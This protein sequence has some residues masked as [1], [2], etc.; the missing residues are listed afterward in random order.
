MNYIFS[1]CIGSFLLDENFRILKFERSQ[2]PLKSNE[3][4]ISG[5]L[6]DEDIAL[7]KYEHEA[8]L[9]RAEKL[10]ENMGYSSDKKLLR[11][12]LSALSTPEYFSLFREA[13]LKICRRAISKS[14]TPDLLII[15]QVNAISELSKSANLLSKRLREWYGL[16]NPELSEEVEDHE[17]FVLKVCSLSK[18]EVRG[19]S[20]M[21]GSLSV[22]QL[23]SLISFA[24]LVR[25]IFEEIRR[26]EA[27]LEEEM[28][29]N[30]PNLTAAVGFSIGA[31]LISLAGGIRQLAEMPSS[32][33]Q[34]LGAEKALFR[35]L[36]TGA[37]PPKYGII[38]QHQEIISASDKE[39]G[40]A[41][42]KLASRAGI[43]A[44]ID[45]FRK[46]QNAD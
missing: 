14:V 42:R 36:K 44:K 23:S 8:V 27:I 4:I 6:T 13:S 31:K 15:Q 1:T 43:A 35:H 3:K 37:R 32:K 24:E 34:V 7:L 30:Y 20:S 17:R 16:Y 28:K 5:H 29:K 19:E 46:V 41:A 40:K 26:Q 2:D 11:K 10:N 22:S 21:G 33:I 39:K 18:E 12:A 45:Y 38:C 25:S 9:L